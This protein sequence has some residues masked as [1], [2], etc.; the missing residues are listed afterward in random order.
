MKL[1][2]FNFVNR[3]YFHCADLRTWDD[4]MGEKANGLY[5]L[6]KR[7][8]YKIPYDL[9]MTLPG[10]RSGNRGPDG[11]FN[12]WGDSAYLWSSS[13]YDSPHAWYRYLDSSH[14]QVYRSHSGK[15]SGFSAILERK[16]QK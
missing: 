3:E 4:W 6:P 16:G 14:A 11:S 7:R 5:L 10:I 12:G 1:T 9:L 15:A 13:Q 2:E 8:L